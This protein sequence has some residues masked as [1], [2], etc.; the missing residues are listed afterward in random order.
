MPDATL[1]P[2]EESGGLGQ[3]T[4]TAATDSVLGGPAATAPVANPSDSPAQPRRSRLSSLFSGL[5]FNW[6]RR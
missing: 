6:L 3:P 4:T 1:P 2:I 5:G